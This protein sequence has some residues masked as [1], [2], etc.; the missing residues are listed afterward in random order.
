MITYHFIPLLVIDIICRSLEKNTAL[1][2][3]VKLFTK[4]SHRFLADLAVFLTSKGLAGGKLAGRMRIP[5]VGAAFHPTST[6]AKTAKLNA[7]FGKLLRIRNKP[8][9][10]FFHTACSV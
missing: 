9:R 7:R 10:Y 6:P 1:P 5:P 8:H 3:Q 4:L 2:R